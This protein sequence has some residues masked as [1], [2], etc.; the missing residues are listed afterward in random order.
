[1]DLDT[2]NWDLWE[3]LKLPNHKLSGLTSWIVKLRENISPGG[4]VSDSNIPVSS[5]GSLDDA[6]KAKKEIIYILNDLDVSEVSGV[7]LTSSDEGFAVRIHLSHKLPRKV[8]KKIPPE[9]YGVPI[10]TRVTGKVKPL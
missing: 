9:I 3:K 2:N 8:I 5:G 4:E 6:Y 10:H 1:M 7:G